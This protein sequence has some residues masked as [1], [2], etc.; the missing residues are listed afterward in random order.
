MIVGYDPVVLSILWIAN[1]RTPPH[2]L[3]SAQQCNLVSAARGRRSRLIRYPTDKYSRYLLSLGTGRIV[4]AGP[5]LMTHDSEA[6][7]QYLDS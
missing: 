1:V 7:V 6:Q 3:L 5:K 2:S 4:L